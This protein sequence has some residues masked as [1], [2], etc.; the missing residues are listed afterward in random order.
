MDENS[1]LFEN[2]YTQSETILGR[3]FRHTFFGTN[4]M[5]TTDILLVGM[6]IYL[7]ATSVLENS[8]NSYL[9][10]PVAF[11]VYQFFLYKS[12]FRRAWQSVL[13]AGNGNP[14]KY[15]TTV[16]ENGINVNVY[17]QDM[18][19]SADRI[20]SLTV[21]KQLMLLYV[22]SKQAII[23]PS[24]AFTIGDAK[25]FEDYIASLGIRISHGKI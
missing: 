12:T 19:Y 20:K 3:F 6:F 15:T 5:I 13:R 1:I 14:P 24:D 7:L 4:F 8:M 23:M 22:D 10:V 2:S 16:T 17:G 11:G 21:T 18:S 9:L 25:G